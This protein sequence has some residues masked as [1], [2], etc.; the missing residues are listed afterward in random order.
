MNLNEIV[1]KLSA[2]GGLG[3][4]INE[5]ARGKW[6]VKLPE[7]SL[8]IREDDCPAAPVCEAIGNIRKGV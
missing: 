1:K 3:D 2:N 8:P 5:A 6:S 7:I 4:A